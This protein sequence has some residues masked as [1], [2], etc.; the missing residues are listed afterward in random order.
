MP[1]AARA[2]QISPAPVPRTVA[3]SFHIP[4]LDGIRAVAVSIV[5]VYHALHG[6]IPGGFGVT[7]FFFLSGFLITTLLRLEAEQTGGV[8]LR[9]FYLRRTLRIL[10]PMY[11][12]LAGAVLANVVTHT[13]ISRPILAL[14][15]LHFTNYLI[16]HVS[17]LQIGTIVLWSLAVE[18]HFYLLFPVAYLA[19]RR[20]IQ[21]P[22]RQAFVLLAVCG[23]LLLWRCV[24]V[25]AL[26][27]SPNYVMYATD[28][29]IDSIL[30][31]CALALW[32]NPALKG[33]QW[34]PRVI[35]WACGVSVV[36]LI[37]T[38]I[39]RNP[40]FQTTLRYSL[41]GIALVPVFVAAIQLSA[42]TPFRFLNH[43]AV[44][45]F[46]VLSYTF[47]LV[48]EP[49]LVLLEKTTQWSTAA[50]FPIALAAA[51]TVSALLHY[52]VERPCARLRRRLA[53]VQ[54]SGALKQ[55]VQQVA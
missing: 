48:H 18:E 40:A 43:P 30:F 28:C 27:V 2:V 51:L 31:G 7:I 29:R 17:R 53:F 34:S 24:L 46:G 10:P 41:Q 45:F 35:A 44:S 5:F 47:Y 39:P 3:G 20:R 25:L 22:E 16:G 15:A 26:G 42:R 33:P 4:S 19:L 38:M 9:N 1:S 21:T 23:A 12:M 54:T 36:V 8:N 49:I 11:I 37:L 50:I 32:R 52:S 55:S 6:V 14:Q 13:P